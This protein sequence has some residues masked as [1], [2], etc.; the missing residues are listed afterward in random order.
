MFANLVDASDELSLVTKPSLALTVFR[1]VPKLQENQSPLSTE[2]LNDL[3]RVFFG[4][5]SHRHD[6]MLTQTSLNGIF[7]VRFAV[8]AARTNEKHIQGAYNIIIQEAK[9][10]H[11]TWNQTINEV[12][13]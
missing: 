10:A 2:S 6:I 3:N 8:G 1:V 5:L 7:C 11:E 13:I 12:A 4:R 9:S